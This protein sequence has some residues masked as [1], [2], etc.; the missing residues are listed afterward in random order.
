[1]AKLYSEKAKQE[2]NHMQIKFMNSDEVD[3]KMW[4]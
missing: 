4:I 3:V 1:M 2:C